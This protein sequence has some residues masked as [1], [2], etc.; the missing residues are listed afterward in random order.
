MRLLLRSFILLSFMLGMGHAEEAKPILKPLPDMSMGSKDAPIVVVNYSSLTCA[1]CA[2]FHTAT[3][4]KIEEKYIKPGYVRIIFR[5]FPAD[6]LAVQAHQLA[7]CKGEIKYMDFVKLLYATQEKWLMAPDPLA[8]L[9]TIALQNGISAEQ[10]EACLKDQELLDK[11]INV[12][13]EGQEKYNITATPTLV[14]NA[15]IYPRALTFEEF[16][17]I[18]RPLLEPTL[19]KEKE[20]AA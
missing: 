10:Y 17:A 16:E 19:E 18:V 2:H 7:W 5:D 4:S 6:Q 9:K 20:K 8:A 14:I 15:K 13:L 11:I 12:R 3:L 1:H